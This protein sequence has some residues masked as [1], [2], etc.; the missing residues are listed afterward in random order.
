[1]R[2][3]HIEVFHAVYSCNSISNAARLLNVSQPSVSKVLRHA[4]DQLGYQLFERVKGKLIPT[5]EGRQLYQE[6]SKLYLNLDSIRR[7]SENLGRMDN[8]LIR[9]AVTP[10]LALDIVPRAVASF[11]E[12][13]PNIRFDIET[14][15]HGEIISSLLEKKID[16]G[17]AFDPSSHPDIAE[18]FLHKCEF[19][20]LAPEGERLPDKSR[21]SLQDLAGKNFISLN[22]KGPL[23]R[24][25][26]S[27][28]EGSN[29][30]L[31]NVA[32]VETYHIAKTLANLGVGCAIV[33]EITARSNEGE[34]VQVRKMAPA[35]KFNIA[36][37]TL[38]NELAPMVCQQFL[39]H[40]SD[41]LERYLSENG[42]NV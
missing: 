34:T 2:L 16:I 42:L 25:L 41:S 20:C 32:N 36:A 10:A 6:V 37:L 18:Q 40:F 39:G 33:D 22:G 7:L 15:H 38:Q 4:E 12:V 9:L 21:I 19:V 3:R 31:N 27:Q 29:I 5:S 11:I 23:G 26:M 13:H 17:I 1:M 14:L 35:L 30:Q 28:L 8:G 24:L